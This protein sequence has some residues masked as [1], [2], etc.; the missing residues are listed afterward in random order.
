[1]S[2][3]LFSEGWID[4][5]KIN[6]NEADTNAITSGEYN[7]PQEIGM[8]KWTDAELAGFTITSDNPLNKLNIERR[9]KN[10]VKRFV[11]GWEPGNNNF[12][13]LSIS[14]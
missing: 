3:K 1:M 10:N 8:R 9:I 11:G 12:E 5:N 14:L 4:V 2:S 6:L 13:A 7:G